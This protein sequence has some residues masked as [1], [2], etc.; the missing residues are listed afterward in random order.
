MKLFLFCHA[1]LPRGQRVPKQRCGLKTVELGIAVGEATM[2][3]PVWQRPIDSVL[4]IIKIQKIGSV[5]RKFQ[6]MIQIYPRI[7]KIYKVNTKYQATAGPAQAKGRFTLYMLY[8]L[9]MFG[10]VWA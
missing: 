4:K 2:L 6:K 5:V 8:I 10:Y 9:E 7:Y 1:P 3:G